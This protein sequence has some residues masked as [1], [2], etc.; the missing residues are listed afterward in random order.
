MNTKVKKALKWAIA[1]LIALVLLYFAFRQ[2]NW[3]EFW[4][5][6]LSCNFWLV[7]ATIVVQWLITWF[8]GNRWQLL[9]QPVSKD[10]KKRE[11][12]H[13][14]ALCYLANMAVTRSGEVAKCG[15]MAE[16]KKVS[17]E[18]AL[19][20]VVIE[21]TWDI[22]CVFIAALPLLFFGKFRDFLV[23]KMFRPAAESVNLGWGWIAL[24]IVAAIVAIVFIIRA[25]KE[26]IERTK[27]GSAILKFFRGMGEGISAAFKMKHKFAFFAYTVI[28]WV[29]YWL[30]SLWTLH[31]FP[32]AVD[33]NG[34][35]ALFLMVV[36]S[37]GWMVPVPG[38]FGAYHLI[39]AMTLVPIYNFT[40]NTGLVFATI[41]HESQSVQ[42]LL[43]GLV[44]L[45]CWAVHKRKQ[46]REI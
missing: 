10:V 7:L 23:E 21:R 9:L 29:G 27:T 35:D 39:V 11:T 12:Y 14:Y 8:R 15:I 4:T 32:A 19:G 41:S 1:F 3:S 43:C 17:F 25:N 45:V 20:T 42:M 46:K 5:S 6:L 37:L 18:G 28:I 2:I 13:A 34:L 22:I 36:G 40:Y 31:A 16:T 30:C 33:M 44:S 24:I 26:R 38:G